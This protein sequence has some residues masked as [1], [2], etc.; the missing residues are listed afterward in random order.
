MS[1]E[2]KKES[3]IK[4]WFEGVL[5]A[6]GESWFGFIIL[7]FIASLAVVI[8]NLAAQDH[9]VRCYYLKTSSTQAGLAYK[10]MA[11]VDWSADNVSFSSSNAKETLNVMADLKQCASK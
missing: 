6:S 5:N 2:I 11:D 9:K 4:E 1:N 10:V 3:L 7:C 8:I